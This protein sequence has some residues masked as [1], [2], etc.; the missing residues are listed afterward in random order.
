MIIK[1]VEHESDGYTNCNWY[2]W[3]SHQRIG[4]RTGG[5][6]NNGTSGD[7]P[8]YGISEIGQNTEKGPGD[9]RRLAITQTLVKDHQLTLV[10]ETL[11]E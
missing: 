10:G 4:T 6:G 7:Y 2:P 8:N 11:K 1:T 5:L 9:L 3:S